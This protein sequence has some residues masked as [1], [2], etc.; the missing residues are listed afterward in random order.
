MFVIEDSMH[1]EIIGEY[2]DLQEVK[3]KFKELL[4]TPWGEGLNRAPC[5]GGDTCSRDYDVTEYDNSKLPRSEI[6]QIAALSISANGIHWY[7]KFD[8]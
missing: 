4:N 8:E 1:S 2:N 7:K 6:N 3:D 5:M